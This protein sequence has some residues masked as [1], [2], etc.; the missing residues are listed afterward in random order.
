[1]ATVRTDIADV[2]AHMPGVKRHVRDEAERR[3][4]RASAKLV[5]HRHDGHARVTTEPG[6][7]DTLVTLDDDHGQRAALSIEFG[8]VGGNLDI[9]GRVVTHMDPLHIITG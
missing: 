3:A 4:A 2:I 9:N 8:R 6:V 5:E 1:M 7:T